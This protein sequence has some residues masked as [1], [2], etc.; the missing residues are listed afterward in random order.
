MSSTTSQLVL[1]RRNL[2]ALG[3]AR[4][5]M[6]WATAWSAVATTVVVC[7][8]AFWALDVLF[9][10]SVPQR[11]LMLLVAAAAV[12]GVFAKKTRP[13]L[14]VHE[15]EIE[16]ALLV[17]RQQDIDSDLVA[18]LQFER[19]EAATWGSRQLETAVVNYVANVGGKLDV[20]A[21]LDKAPLARRAK[22]LASVGLVLAALAAIFPGHAA[23]LLNRLFLGHR[24]YPT[25]TTI[26][27]VIV[28]QQRVLEHGEDGTQPRGARAAQSHPVRFWI[29]CA[30]V[31]PTNA[32]LR[33]TGETTQA[34]RQLDLVPVTLD[35]RRA[36]LVAI[37]EQITK[38][39]AGDEA[40]PS[41]TRLAEMLAALRTDAAAAAANWPDEAAAGSN[42]RDVS[43]AIGGV[44][45]QWP[46]E[47]A[48]TSVYQGE[49]GRLVDSVTYKLY[50]GDAWTDPASVA[51]I[52]LPVI[53]PRL[54]V[55][56]PD[57]ARDVAAAVD[58]AARQISVLEGSRLDVGL[59]CTNRKPLAAAWISWQTPEGPQSLPLEAVDKERHDWRLPTDN[60]KFARVRDEMRFDLQVRDEDGLQLETPIG[61]LV[62][63][64]ADRP[65]TAG[66]DVVH[67]VVLPGA[68]P[69]VEYR[70]NDDFGIA[71][72][73]LH[74]ETEAGQNTTKAGAAGEAPR[75][76]EPKPVQRRSL[77]LLPAGTMLGA[78]E[79]PRIAPYELDLR[80]LDLVKGDRI[81]LTLEATDHR[82]STPG[83]VAT[84]EPLYLEI[85]DE[86][87]VLAAILEADERSEQRLSEI[88][89]RQLG[90]GESP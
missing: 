7:I 24:H 90:I 31:L 89:K 16:L 19:P 38:V 72:I 57:Y 5:R 29:Q 21:G 36:R 66:I 55:V 30:G 17:E 13:L 60:A 62:R 28:N 53:E 37:Q 83:E 49:L 39:A 27:Q 63:I 18:A 78:A 51:M 22:A 67:R 44:L 33:L 70:V 88:I 12:G 68:R 46:G 4:Q 61:L 56:P 11:L 42:W 64:R 81:K 84:S 50:A 40:P 85:S 43:D 76:S 54:T 86:S 87:G 9:E 10:M 20:Y 52:P 79:L 32:H 48:K 77:E 8:L 34:M 23:T 73:V 6:R 1:L 82:G 15:S 80:P 75:E 69:R 41:G 3:A 45:K 58:P 47:A 26:V 2:A 65:P 59:S 25:R 74:V 35:E 14:G 71:K